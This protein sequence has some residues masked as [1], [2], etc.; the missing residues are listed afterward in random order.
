MV[1]TSST[2]SKSESEVQ[3]VSKCFNVEQSCSDTNAYH[4]L[5]TLEDVQVLVKHAAG[6]KAVVENFSLELYSDGKLGYLGSHQRLSVNIKT[7]SEKYTLSFFVKAV[8]YNIPTQAEYV[9][10]KCVFLKEKI[11]YRDI[12][13]QLYHE[14][15]GEPWTATCFL[16]KDNLLVF[17]DL[18]TKG[19][20]LRTKLFNKELIVS[21]LTAIAKLH[22]SCLLAEARLGKTFKKMYPHA[23]IENAFSETGKTKKW[24]D[25]SVNAIVAIA[26]HLGLDATL[27]PKACEKVHAALEMS[28]TKRNVISHGDLWGNNLMFSNTVPPNCLLLDFQLMRYSPLAHDVA[29]FLYLTADKHFR[30]TWEES[31]LKH[32]YSVLRETMNSTK[33]VSLEIP[34]WSELIEGMEEQ[35]LAAIITA[36]IYF[37][38]VLLDKKTSMEIM[39][40]SIGYHEYVFNNRNETLLKVMKTDPVYSKRLT[41]IVSELVEYSFRLDELPKPT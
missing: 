24:F 10:D 2:M 21:G 28:S 15:K 6:G 11:F 41:E 30:V 34:P 12:I 18:E 4:N 19:Y 16:V 32:Y 8:P 3:I 1:F 33:S 23:F 40:D 38:T 29:N 35:R 17:E 26:E 7:V 14:Y 22:A 25:V 37:Q 9:L 31:M 39:N 5:L 27:I 20:S 36:A 13:P